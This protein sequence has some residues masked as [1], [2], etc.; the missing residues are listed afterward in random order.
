MTPYARVYGVHPA[1]FNFD[2]HG[3]MQPTQEG[4]IQMQMGLLAG[5]TPSLRGRT[6]LVVQGSPGTPPLL[7]SPSR[8]YPPLVG[9]DFALGEH[10]LV[11]TDDGVAWMDGE[12][13][14]VYPMDCEAE[15]YFIPGG[16]VKVCYDRGIKWV[17]PDNMSATLRKRD[18]CQQSADDAAATCMEPPPL[19]QQE[20]V[21]R[22]R[23]DAERW[24]SDEDEAQE[25]LS[26]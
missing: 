2:R 17:M 10:L 7:T 21:G 23:S 12:V 11:L 20:L 9:V 25:V 18:A 4:L 26:L 22:A 6:A 3:V 5:L 8:R 19:G 1:Y 16:T 24:F 13:V 14:N 15:G